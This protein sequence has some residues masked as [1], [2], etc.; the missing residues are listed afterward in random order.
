V[1]AAVVLA[2]L[3][4]AVTPA[5]KPVALKATDPLKPPRGAIVMIAVPLP[6][7]ATFTLETEE[8]VKPGP[9]VTVKAMAA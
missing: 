2:G 7:K 6:P 4:D 9:G 1:L 3:K 8:S 5:G